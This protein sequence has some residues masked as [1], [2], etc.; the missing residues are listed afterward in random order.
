HSLPTRRS[1]DLVERSTKLV[2]RAAQPVELGVD[3]AFGEV[4]DLVVVVLAPEPRLLHRS[5]VELL[6]ITSVQPLGEPGRLGRDARGTRLDRGDRR[7]RR[8]RLARPLA[9]ASTGG[10]R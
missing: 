4:V 1:S 8:L 9:A 3:G 7:I 5:E 6:F 2:D 10:K